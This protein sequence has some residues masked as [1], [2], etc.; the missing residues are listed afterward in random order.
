L[1][2]VIA[3]PFIIGAAACAAPADDA[4]SAL[5]RYYAACRNEEIDAYM[6]LMDFSDGEDLTEDHIETA[7]DLALAVWEAYDILRQE[8]SS[9]E[10][11]VDEDGAYALISYHIYQELQG[12]DSEGQAAIATM[13]LDYVAL[14]HHVERWKVVYLM[15]RGT[16]EENM[17]NLSPVIAVADAIEGSAAEQ[18]PGDLPPTASFSLMPDAPEVGDSVVVVS[19]SSD[20][21][22]DLLT[23]SW[24]L[25]GVR[26]PDVDNQSDWEWTDVDAGEHTL[27]LRVEDGKGGSDESSR[28]VRVRAAGQESSNRPPTASFT[29]MPQDPTP[30]D[31]IVGVST[32]SDPD[33]DALLYSWFVNGEYDANMGTLSE[34]TWANPA[35]GEY[36]IGL[37]VMDGRGGIGEYSM[38][39]TVTPDGEE[40]WSGS[41]SKSNMLFFLLIPIA[42]VIAVLASRRGRKGIRAFGERL[43]R[44]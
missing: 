23:T 1:V 20:P 9:T 32:S 17:Q 7:R 35:E 15:P 40:A 39:V 11:S 8:I 21:D 13:D 26:L 14:M 29:L 16:F 36:T 44:R 28:I 4:L 38:T 10:I 31:A 6:E 41:N 30:E 3:I 42:A 25:N 12:D 5:H 18:E 22:G 2:L 37:V 43:M 33:G 34:W 24:T 19:T 27:T